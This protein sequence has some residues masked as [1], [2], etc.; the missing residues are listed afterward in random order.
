M[1]FY[2][3]AQERHINKSFILFSDILKY[4]SAL[5]DASVT[6]TSAI[7][8]TAVLILSVARN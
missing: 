1:Y 4:S 8:M 3:K 7:C 6:S 2:C 5:N